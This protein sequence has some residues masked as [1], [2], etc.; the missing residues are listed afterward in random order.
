MKIFIDSADIDEIKQAYAWGIA[1]GVTTNPS[2]MKKAVD[3]RKKRGEKINLRSY[4]NSILKVAKG[5]PVSLEVTE[6]SAAGMIK[7]GKALYKMFN[8]V[9]K[10]VY[11][12]IPINSAFSEKDDQFAGIRVI[13][14]LT[15]LKIPTNCTLV[16]TT[17]QALLAAKAG[18]SFISPFAGRIDDYIRTNNKIKFEKTDYWPAEGFVKNKKLLNDH[19]IY[20]GVDLVYQINMVLK[21]YGFKSEVLAASLRN[22]QQVSECAKSGADI[23]TLPLSVIR[24]MLKHPKTYQGMAAFTK[25]IVP[26]YVKLTK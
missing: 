4:I 18:A 25:D 3:V 23:A 9:A 6:T 11:I 8:P 12:K 7:Q 10:N 20:S 14:A 19:G 22:T 17:A 26:E 2:L 21:H 16:F 13:K 5:T 15:K 1:D 24:E